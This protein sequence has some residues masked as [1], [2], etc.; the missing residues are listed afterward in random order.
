MSQNESESAQASAFET[1]P[2]DVV[3][4]LR[5]V[6]AAMVKNGD[7]PKEAIAR[8]AAMEPFGRYPDAVAGLADS[9]EDAW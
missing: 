4:V 1:A 3:A 5:E 2:D 7:P 8:L 6:Y 9:V